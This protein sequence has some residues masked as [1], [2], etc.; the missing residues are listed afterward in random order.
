MGFFLSRVRAL[1][2]SK[3]KHRSASAV[4]IAQRCCCKKQGAMPGKSNSASLKLSGLPKPGE[5]IRAVFLEHLNLD[6][7]TDATIEFQWYKKECAQQR[8]EEYHHD[9]HHH[10]QQ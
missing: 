9:H 4:V 8:K 6:S 2:V 7:N 1:C 10:Q 5:A 3:R